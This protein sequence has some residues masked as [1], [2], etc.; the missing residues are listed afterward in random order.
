MPGALFRRPCVQAL[1]CARLAAVLP[2]AQKGP[3]LPGPEIGPKIRRPTFRNTHFPAPTFSARKW[4]RAEGRASCSFLRRREGRSGVRAG[5]LP[6]RGGLAFVRRGT[7]VLRASSF[8][9]CLVCIAVA[10]MSRECRV[11]SGHSSMSI[12]NCTPM[13]VLLVGVQDALSAA[14]VRCSS[15]HVCSTVCGS[16]RSRTLATF[17]FA[18]EDVAGCCGP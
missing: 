1:P 6:A 7:S 11:W 3:R 5:S 4:A 8:E 18:A 15:G 17:A 14:H 2:G 16:G 12:L 9:R 10:R 13:S